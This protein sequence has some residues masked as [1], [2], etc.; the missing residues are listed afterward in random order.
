MCRPT[1]NRSPRCCRRGDCVVVD[2]REQHDRAIDAQ[3]IRGLVWKVRH[4]LIS[5]VLFTL[6]GLPDVHQ[7]IGTVVRAA[8]L[9]SLLIA[10]TSAT[11]MYRLP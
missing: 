7:Q 4:R 5:F 3:R 9:R 1:I 2:S 8:R 6:L 10:I 11:D